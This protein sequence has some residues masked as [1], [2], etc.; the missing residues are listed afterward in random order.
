[1]TV[2]TAATFPEIKNMV[3]LARHF[4][5]AGAVSTFNVDIPLQTSVYVKDKGYRRANVPAGSGLVP[6][7]IYIGKKQGLIF[8]FKPASEI[9]RD[10]API[11]FVEMSWDDLVG[12][13]PELHVKL[14]E[15]LPGGDASRFVWLIDKGIRSAIDKN[16]SIHAVLSDGF[17]KAQ[18]DE[19]EAATEQLEENPLWGAF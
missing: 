2:D 11:E 13:I 15:F 9:K 5:R 19:R 1:M 12:S 18:E 8:R 3:I 16:P 14:N 7:E 17:K 10:G 4:L 6:E